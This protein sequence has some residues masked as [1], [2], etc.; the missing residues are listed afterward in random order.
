MTATRRQPRRI[1][2]V[3]DCFSTREQVSMILGCQG[4]LV[5]TAGNGEEAL[6]KLRSQARPDL[7][8]LDLQMPVMDGWTL[9]EELGRHES[10]CSIPVVVLTGVGEAEVGAAKLKGVVLLHKPVETAELLR[11]V[12]N[13]CGG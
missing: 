13:C 8:L 9:R 12:Q 2:L 6:E 5:S 10:W 11:T 3:E 4:Y 7:I 1:L